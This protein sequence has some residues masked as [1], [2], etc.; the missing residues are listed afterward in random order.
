ML[1]LQWFVDKYLKQYID[2]L[3][4]Q[5]FNA[6]VY[7]KYYEGRQK[8]LRQRINNIRRGLHSQTQGVHEAESTKV[9]SS[10]GV[11]RRSDEPNVSPPPNQAAIA[12]AAEMDA[13]RKKLRGIKE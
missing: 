11:R 8:E 3:V 10:S 1:M 13:M 5:R 2:E 12:K 4:D 7:E 6:K 9:L